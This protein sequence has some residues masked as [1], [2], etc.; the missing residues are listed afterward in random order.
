M[1]TP[2]AHE[3]L[4]MGTGQRTLWRDDGHRV[5]KLVRIYGVDILGA[6]AFLFV[7]PDDL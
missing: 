3:I 1:D 5:H 7:F 2:A 4:Y 6:G